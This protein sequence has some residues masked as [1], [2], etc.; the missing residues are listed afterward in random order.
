MQTTLSHTIA[1]LRTT[2]DT[3]ALGLD[4]LGDVVRQLQTEIQ[5]LEDLDAL[6]NAE[7]I[8]AHGAREPLSAKEVHVAL[9][10]E[11]RTQIEA[12]RP[13]TVR[14]CHYLH[15]DEPDGLL[16]AFAT[17]LYESGR[18]HLSL[19]EAGQ[20]RAA[21]ACRRSDS[22]VVENARTAVVPS[23][24]LGASASE[25][26]ELAARIRSNHTPPAVPFHRPENCFRCKPRKASKA[27]KPRKA[28][29][30]RSLLT[31]RVNDLLR[32]RDELRRRL[33][34]LAAV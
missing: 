4:E 27:S 2:F 6:M 15:Q 31:D 12:L 14:T 30:S 16:W 32:Q 24:F 17:S 9:W 21:A 7:P 33:T 18:V 13:W 1:Q 20:I 10:R 29:N 8:D 19:T 23:E 3:Q 28:D 22:A 26:L 25:T 34:D 5:R 11:L